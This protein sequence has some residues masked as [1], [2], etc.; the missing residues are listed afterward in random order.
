MNYWQMTYTLAFIRENM[1]FNEVKD[2]LEKLGA[3]WKDA[4]DFHECIEYEA[5]ILIGR[6]SLELGFN[7]VIDSL[8]LEKILWI[9]DTDESVYEGP[10]E[11]LFEEVMPYW[12]LADFQV[13]FS[14]YYA[15][16]SDNF[17]Y[18]PKEVKDAFN[19]FESW[20]DDVN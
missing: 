13:R 9:Y 4:K 18:Y 5:F 15:N 20:W 16:D 14:N 1:T 6:Y 19:I 3:E 8:S 17:R 7:P 10:D 2:K 12:W 11:A